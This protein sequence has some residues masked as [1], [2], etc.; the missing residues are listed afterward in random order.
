MTC[1]GR[2]LDKLVLAGTRKIER[3]PGELADL[4][5]GSSRQDVESAGGLLLALNHKGWGERWI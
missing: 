4:E 1:S 3:V 2:T 5:K